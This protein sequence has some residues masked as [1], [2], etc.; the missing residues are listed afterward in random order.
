MP[1]TPK[2]MQTFFV[3]IKCQLG[4]TYEVASALATS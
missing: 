2:G 4:K 1:P 3:E